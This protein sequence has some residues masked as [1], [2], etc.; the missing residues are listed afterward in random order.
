MRAT[1]ALSL[2]VSCILALPLS[3]MQASTHPFLAETH[4]TGTWTVTHSCLTGCS[5]QLTGTEVVKHFRGNVYDAAGTQALVLFRI[6][7]RVLVYGRTGSTLLTVRDPGLLMRGQGVT[8]GGSTFS[9][10]WRCVA[11]PSGQARKGIRPARL[12]C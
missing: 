4:L 6:G 12:M 7:K 8:A 10:T 9:S 1:V 11:R 2:L 3:G 5:Q